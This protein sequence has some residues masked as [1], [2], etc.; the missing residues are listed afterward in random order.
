MI[1]KRVRG[2]SLTRSTSIRSVWHGARPANGASNTEVVHLLRRLRAVEMPDGPHRCQRLT[3]GNRPR[4]TPTTGA[5]PVP[6]ALLI[7]VP[8]TATRAP[9]PPATCRD[10]VTVLTTHRY[11]RHP[12][13]ANDAPG[14]TALETTIGMPSRARRASRMSRRC[15]W[16]PGERCSRMGEP[17]DTRA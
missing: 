6:G 14:G 8:R 17:F 1:V 9:A 5:D 11:L 10:A 4:Q 7:A 12:A 2:A 16:E 3:P 15:R 13:D